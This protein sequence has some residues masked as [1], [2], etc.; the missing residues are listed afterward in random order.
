MS[1]YH[2]PSTVS[3]SW[4][5]LQTYERILL[6]L[7]SS[8]RWRNWVRSLSVFPLFA[9]DTQSKSGASLS[10]ASYQRLRLWVRAITT[11]N[12]Y[13]I[14]P[15]TY[16]QTGGCLL[17]CG[18]NL[19][20]GHICRSLVELLGSLLSLFSQPPSATWILITTRPHSVANNVC[21]WSAYVSTPASDFVT[22]PA[23]IASS[24]SP[25]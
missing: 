2:E 24:R 10:P 8:M 18:F 19:S 13:V 22:N 7:Q 23:E 12:N 4:A 11:S 9:R 14:N 1:L 5:T 25:T 17:T 3:I 16:T 21:A 15:R 20:C 6:G